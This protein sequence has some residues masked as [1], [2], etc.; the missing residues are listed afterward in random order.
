MFSWG[1]CSSCAG[2]CIAM[3]SVQETLRKTPCPTD[4]C[5]VVDLYIFY[6]HIW[7]GGVGMQV[8]RRKLPLNNF[9]QV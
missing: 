7:G 2:S 5:S 6:K 3:L 9:S 4:K 1:I 8:Q